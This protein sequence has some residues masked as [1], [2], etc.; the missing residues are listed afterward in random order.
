MDASGLKFRPRHDPRVIHLWRG[1]H[2]PDTLLDDWPVV[3][4]GAEFGLMMGQVLIEAFFEIVSEPGHGL[5]W[6]NTRVEGRQQVSQRQHAIGSAAQEADVCF[7]LGTKI[8]PKLW[9]D[10]FEQRQGFIAGEGCGIHGGFQVDLFE[11][12]SRID[13]SWTTTCPSVK[14]FLLAPQKPEKWSNERSLW[15]RLKK[16]G[17]RVDRRVRE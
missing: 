1:A 13:L 3:G 2:D 12:Y 14:Q 5:L 9:S 10:F 16:L 15:H 17:M 4:L 7:H 8:R 11:N 6:S